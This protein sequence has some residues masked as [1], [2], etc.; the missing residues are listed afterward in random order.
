VSGGQATLLLIALG[1]IVLMGLAGLA[2]LAALVRAVL[3][4]EQRLTAEMNQ[5]RTELVATAEQV[6]QTSRQVGVVLNEV[7]RGARYAA[8]AVELWRLVRPRSASGRSAPTLSRTLW[9]RVGVPLGVLAVRA[10]S[11]HVRSGPPKS[12]GAAG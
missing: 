8:M 4:M 6:R 9:T 3:R 7:S 5:V 12:P 2:F 11:A 1:V 10:L